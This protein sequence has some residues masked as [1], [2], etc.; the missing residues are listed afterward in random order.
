MRIEGAADCTTSETTA[1]WE[2][3]ILAEAFLLPPHVRVG[4]GSG[5]GILRRTLRR[6][7][8]HHPDVASVAEPPQSEGGR[9]WSCVRRGEE[10]ET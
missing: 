5:R 7:L 10:S 2:R 8:G 6:L 3:T 1:Q 4:H 9:W